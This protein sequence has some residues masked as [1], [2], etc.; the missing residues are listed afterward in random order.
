MLQNNN[1]KAV[2]IT[3]DR[4]MPINTIIPMKLLF[5]KALKNSFFAV[6]SLEIDDKS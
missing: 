1:K 5:K 6:F 4:N 2:Q 3:T